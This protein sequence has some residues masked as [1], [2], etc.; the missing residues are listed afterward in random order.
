MVRVA[1][2]LAVVSAAAPQDEASKTLWNRMRTLR[3]DVDFSKTTLPDFVNYLREVADINIVLSPKAEISTPITI[4]A[5][6]V[7]VSALLRLLL[8]PNRIGWRIEDGVLMIV[9]DSELQSA[10]RLEIIDVR[11]L[12]LP[13]RDFPGIEITLNTDDVGVSMSMQEDEVQEEF[14]IVDLVKAH[15][16]GKSWD[17]NPRASI[18]LMNGLL[19][20][21]NTDEVILQVRRIVA[22]LRKYK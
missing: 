11:D 19:F 5:K 18:R 20:V 21:R 3:L 22:S 7:T 9:P 8:K 14:P 12:L 13:I 15:V 6:D 16:G 4:K 17:E 1:L 2:L 10:V